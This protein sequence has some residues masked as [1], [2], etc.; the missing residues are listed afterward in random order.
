MTTPFHP[1]FPELKRLWETG[2]I[3]EFDRESKHPDA[4]PFLA[5]WN[6]SAP[7]DPEAYAAFFEAFSKY[8]G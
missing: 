4:Q 1:A 6:A 8:C 3:M 2:P 7:A 5:L